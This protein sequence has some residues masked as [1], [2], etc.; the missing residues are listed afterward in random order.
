LS[1]A[2]TQIAAALPQQ[3]LPE[4]QFAELRHCSASL[5]SFWRVLILSRPN[6]ETSNWIL[7]SPA[8]AATAVPVASLAYEMM[9]RFDDAAVSSGK[10]GK[11]AQTKPAVLA[12]D[13][14]MTDIADAYNQNLED[15]QISS[16]T[17][18]GGSRAK[19]AAR[20]MR[21]DAVYKLS[22]LVLACDV[23]QRRKEQRG[24][25]QVQAVARDAGVA[26]LAVPDHHTGKSTVKSVPQPTELATLQPAF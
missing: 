2:C 10:A 3:Q 25:S 7:D 21:S 15:G 8:L 4:A 9:L 5:L 20:V 14:L 1:T 24:R 19:Q 6:F 23:R 26:R 16:S 11:D 12:A 18:A 17:A 13:A 22:L